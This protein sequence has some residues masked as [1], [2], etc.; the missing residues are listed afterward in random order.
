VVLHNIIALLLKLNLMCWL[1]V[2]LLF[3]KRLGQE[4]CVYSDAVANCTDI[5]IGVKKRQNK[6]D[7]RLNLL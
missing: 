6:Q 2:V 1:Q 7:S 4:N 3:E 5:E